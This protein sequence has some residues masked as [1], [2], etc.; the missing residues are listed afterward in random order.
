MCKIW[1]TKWNDNKRLDKQLFLIYNKFCYLYNYILFKKLTN[2][3]F[4]KI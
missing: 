1:I 2:I 3:V 4:I